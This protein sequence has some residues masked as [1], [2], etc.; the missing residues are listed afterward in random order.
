MQSH[1]VQNVIKITDASYKT[2]H[3]KIILPKKQFKKMAQQ[4]RDPMQITT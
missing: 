4:T 2:Q 3:K 1:V